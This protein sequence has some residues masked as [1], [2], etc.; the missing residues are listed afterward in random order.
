[1]A[2]T[3]LIKFLN[4]KRDGWLPIGIFASNIFGQ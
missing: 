4:I 1:M 3:Q 2:S